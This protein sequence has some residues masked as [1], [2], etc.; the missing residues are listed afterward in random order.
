MIEA[1]LWQAK[2]KRPPRL[3]PPRPRRMRLGE[4]VQV[5]GSLHDWFEGRGPRCCLIAFIDRASRRVM[6]ARLK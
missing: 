5:D 6:V 2:Q 1:G 3:H 4:L